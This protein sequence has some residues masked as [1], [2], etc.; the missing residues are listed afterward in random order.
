[1]KILL[2]VCLSA[3]AF[4]CHAQNP[5][6]EQTDKVGSLFGFT[7]KIPTTMC[8]WASKKVYFYGDSYILGGVGVGSSAYR[9]STL[10][11]QYNKGV[12][13]NFGVNSGVISLS[14]N[15]ISGC[16]AVRP[17]FDTTTIRVYNSAQDTLI[18]FHYG[19]NDC[20]TNN[21]LHIA[22]DSFSYYVQQAVRATFNHGWPS[23]LQVWDAIPYQRNAA[24][25]VGP[26]SVTTEA[27]DAR[28]QQFSDTIRAICQRNNLV[29]HDLRKWQQEV[30]NIDSLV[31]ATDGIHPDTAGY[32]YWARRA[33]G[34]NEYPVF[35]DSTV[36]NFISQVPVITQKDAVS[37]NNFILGCKA[38]GYY[39]KIKQILPNYGSWLLYGKVAL[40][41]P[42]SVNH[43]IGKFQG[44]YVGAIGTSFGLDTR[45]RPTDFV[46][47][48][49]TIFLSCRTDV[50]EVK[51]D[52]GTLTST[53]STE[54]TALLR[55][56]SDVA[57][58]HGGGGTVSTFSN[59][60]SIGVYA[61]ACT[62]TTL[63]S[64]KAGSQ[65]D[66]KT[67]T[68]VFTNPDTFFIGNG[69]SGAL[70]GTKTYGMVLLC[71][72]MNS[73]EIAALSARIQTLETALG[74]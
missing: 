65:V 3:I 11:C 27:T 54:I 30:T 50:Q 38:D 12:E 22:P 44:G 2:G 57:Q 21:T 9:Y 39:S 4:T 1:M 23:Y 52:F 66:T 43:G 5:R 16:A 47:S 31:F 25:Y 34:L 59:T 62:P 10:L 32:N 15:N 29:Y 28:A 73:T 35:Y 64:Y 58:V 55:N 51:I 33:A 24:Q 60:S 6:K 17:P 71:D 14:V 20:Y 53:F 7:P 42:N 40:L 61:F 69:D 72:P 8:N 13:Q 67:S 56:G 18:F 49:I 26:C 19:F 48:G 41:G 63:T 45:A 68:Y 37:F 70:S 36:I 46:N 74:R